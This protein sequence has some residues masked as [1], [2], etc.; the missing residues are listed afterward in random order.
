M[1]FITLF[2]LHVYLC[3]NAMKKRG[4]GV[5]ITSDCISGEREW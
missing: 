1:N 5:G 3:V 2:A 4:G